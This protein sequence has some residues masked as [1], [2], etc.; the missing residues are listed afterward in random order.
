M[1][2]WSK[3]KD[4][5]NELSI[6]WPVLSSSV[7]QQAYLS[8]QWSRYGTCSGLTQLQYFQTALRLYDAIDLDNK[9]SSINV[10]PGPT[11]YDPYTVLDNYNARFGLYPRIWCASRSVSPLVEMIARFEF[12]INPDGETVESIPAAINLCRTSAVQFPP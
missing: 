2:D 3:I 7:T 10:F 6:K 9:L 1:L 11:M 8:M 12:Q 5:E 4:L